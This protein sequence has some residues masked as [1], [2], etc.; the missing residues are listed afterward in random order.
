MLWFNAW[1]CFFFVIRQFYSC[2]VLCFSYRNHRFIVVISLP[3][4]VGTKSNQCD[5]DRSV[6]QFYVA[7]TWSTAGRYERTEWDKHYKQAKNK[8]NVPM[9]A[10]HTWSSAVRWSHAAPWAQ[11][12]A[13]HQH[14][15]EWQVGG[16][17]S[18]SCFAYGCGG[19]VRRWGEGGGASDDLAA[20]GRRW[21]TEQ[22][23]PGAPSPL[24]V[25]RD[26]LL[27]QR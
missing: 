23:V 17:E 15:T 7:L 20:A 25:D 13:T 11:L 9:I 21:G 16:T 14:M 24:D 10:G 4:S 2:T 5:D 8:K 18:D 1:I 12:S 26:G 22:A 27:T 6:N 3:D 19:D